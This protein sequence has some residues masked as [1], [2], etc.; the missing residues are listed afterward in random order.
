MI[1]YIRINY[2]IITLYILRYT[3]VLLYI[4]FLHF[5]RYLNQVISIFMYLAKK[6]DIFI[7]DPP[8]ICEWNDEDK[9]EQKK[10]FTF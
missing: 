1:L 9:K 10:P 6:C 3:F 8:Y 4:N 5:G 7:T 2:I